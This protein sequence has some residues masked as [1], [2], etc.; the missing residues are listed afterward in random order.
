MGI[1]ALSWHRRYKERKAWYVA[2]H[3]PFHWSVAQ[4]TLLPEG[5]GDD[6]AFAF[7][8]E[9]LNTMAE[10]NWEAAVTRLLP[11]GWPVTP[12]KLENIV[13][14][15]G[16]LYWPGDQE[17]TYQPSPPYPSESRDHL[18]YLRPDPYEQTGSVHPEMPIAVYW[19]KHPFVP[20]HLGS[21]V[22][23]IPLDGSWS[24]L[25]AEFELWR[26][27]PGLFGFELGRL[28]VA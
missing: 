13:C 16:S 11:R 17:R 1:R 20:D 18:S 14:N 7:A 26:V 12:A 9:W 10:G 24:D 28:D 21:L 3:E 23:W 2:I 15:Y 5:C 27:A 19:R 6:Q 4:S 25:S 22:T 8:I